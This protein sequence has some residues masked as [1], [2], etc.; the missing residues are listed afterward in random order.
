MPLAD[1]IPKSAPIGFD[2]VTVKLS[3]NLT[4]LSPLT[5]MVIVFDD[6]SAPNSSKPL[7]HDP[8]KSSALA[9]LSPLPVTAN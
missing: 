6:S 7:G 3:S 8:P 1:D 9:G 5:L 4:V 2:N